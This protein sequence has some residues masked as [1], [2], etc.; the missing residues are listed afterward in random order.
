MC[1]LNQLKHVFTCVTFLIPPSLY[2]TSP[3]PVNF[4][5]QFTQVSAAYGLTTT[6][7]ERSLG[8]LNCDNKTQRLCVFFFLIFPAFHI[9]FIVLFSHGFFSI[10]CEVH[11]SVVF[12]LSFGINDMSIVHMASHFEL[13]S[14]VKSLT[15][16]MSI[17]VNRTSPPQQFLYPHLLFRTVIVKLS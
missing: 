5:P 15:E 6:T 13:E 11:F 2:I 7:A 10:G 17:A 9:E 3:M 1:S 16:L 14:E 8:R 4:I 12:G